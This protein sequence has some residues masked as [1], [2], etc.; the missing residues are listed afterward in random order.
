MIKIHQILLKATLGIVG[1]ILLAFIYINLP[2]RLPKEAYSLGVTFSALQSEALGLD[3]RANYLAMLDELNI[4]KVR[5]PVNWSR[6][7]AVEGEFDFS[8]L[9]WQ[10]AEAGKRQVE[11]VLVVGQKVP[12]W[13]EC[14]IPEWAMQD[15]AKRKKAL[16]DVIRATVGRYKENSAV[17][18]W[19]VENEPFLDFGICPELDVELLEREVATVRATDPSRPV[20]LTDSGEIGPW[21]RAAKRGDIFGTTMYREV[22]TR[23]GHWKYPIGPNFF[24]IKKWIIARFFDQ[25][26]IM[27]IELQGEPWLKGWT[28]GFPLEDQFRSMNPE[29]LRDNVEFARKTGIRDI[30]LW[31]VEWWYWLKIKKDY[32]LIWDMVGQL[33]HSGTDGYNN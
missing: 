13:P 17:R 2:V 7:E 11:L 22:I 29:I 27:V 16:V 24:K 4:R 14:F 31:G 33:V 10:V 30:Y 3:W 32:P 8:D 18:I 21:F 9:D 26:R 20:M 23:Y 12:R 5:L 25:D 19:Q 1:L 28:I 15:D 6:I